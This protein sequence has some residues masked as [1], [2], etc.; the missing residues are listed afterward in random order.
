MSYLVTALPQ[1]QFF[2]ALAPLFSLCLGWQQY[3]T[4][5]LLGASL[6]LVGLLTLMIPSAAELLEVCH[7]IYVR[8]CLAQIPISLPILGFVGKGNFIKEY[9]C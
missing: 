9:A 3:P 8:A 1:L 7:P 2:P 6:S 5:T 4:A